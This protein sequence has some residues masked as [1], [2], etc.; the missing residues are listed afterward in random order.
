MEP[1]SSS[2]ISQSEIAHHYCLKRA[3]GHPLVFPETLGHGHTPPGRKVNK[4]DFRQADVAVSVFTMPGTPRYI[5][6]NL[7]VNSDSASCGYLPYVARILY[8]I[9]VCRPTKKHSSQLVTSI[10]K[11]CGDES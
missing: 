11:T 8:I 3:Q 10:P 4:G 5:R 1:I 7:L 6:T 9:I 2:D